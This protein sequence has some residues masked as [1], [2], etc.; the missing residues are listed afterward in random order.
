MRPY[1]E[2]EGVKLYC[3][4]A[5]ELLPLFPSGS[6]D[7]ILTDPPYGDTALAWDSRV[8][9]QGLVRSL[10]KPSGSLW[11]FGSMRMF[12]ETNFSGWKLAQDVVWE[13]QNG[14]GFDKD[15]FR[16]V[17]EHALQFYPEG[18]PWATVFKSP[19]FTMDA[20]AKTVA[21]R[22]STPHRGA[23]NAAPF[24][25]E[26]G[27]PRLMRSVWQVRNCHGNAVHPTQKPEGVIEPLLRYSSPVG[28]VVLDP[29]AGSGTTLVVARRLGMRAVGF[30]ISEEYCEAAAKR[31]LSAKPA[32][33]RSTNE[34]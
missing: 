18:A 11:C 9:W 32:V 12:L 16:R 4:N 3:G 8:E 10:L 14:S 17:H 31:L 7:L 22:G 23:I 13:K 6:L 2:T 33:L 24:K 20:K 28:G 34:A 29:F 19:V 1:F 26:D 5:L 21:R 27:G 30:E 25:S 15:R